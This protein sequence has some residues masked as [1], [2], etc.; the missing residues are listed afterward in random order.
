MCMCMCVC[1]RVRVC[2]FACVLV[3][4]SYGVERVVHYDFI[5][6]DHLCKWFKDLSIYGSKTRS[7]SYN[8]H[9]RVIYATFW[10]IN[11]S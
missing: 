1:V 10:S 3:C 4:A 5:N 2:V 7:Q 9:F 11:K 6:I 8:T